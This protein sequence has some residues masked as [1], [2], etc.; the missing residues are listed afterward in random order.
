VLAACGPCDAGSFQVAAI[1]PAAQVTSDPTG[2]DVTY[3]QPATFSVACSGYPVP[4]VQW[5]V[6]PR[7]GTTWGADTVDT[8]S[9]HTGPGTVSSALTLTQ[10][11]VTDS[12][13]EY[14][15]VC[16]NT[17]GSSTSTAATLTVA[18]APL[19][20]TAP[21]PAIS[22]GQA[23]PALTPSY[24]G[25]VAGDSASSLTTGATCSLP[26]GTPAVPGAGSYT[27]T[28]SGPADPNYAIS[29]VNGTL[30][31]AAPPATTSS[32]T[33]TTNPPAT[34]SSTS[35]SVFV[36]IPPSPTT[37]PSGAAASLPLFPGA[38]LSYPNGAVVDFAGTAYVFAGGHAFEVASAQDLASVRKVDPAKVVGALPGATVP[39]AVPRP[40]TLLSTRAVNGNPTIYVMGTD[41]E[42]HAFSTMHQFLSDGYDPALVVTV[43]D[44]GGI[45]TGS[46]AGV[47]GQAVTAL[48]TR[49]DGAIVD[50]SGTFY[51][52]AG[53]EAFGIATP[54]EL[55]EVRRLDTAEVLE[56]H[57]ATAPSGPGIA[58]GVLL[59]V[60]GGHVF[61][62]YE[63]SIYPFKTSAQF[64]ADGYT[65]TAAVPVPGTGQLTV[66]LPYSGK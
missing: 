30:T 58:G 10:P 52:Y 50:S 43:P 32:T 59:G 28:C 40:G 51:V 33:P 53:Q 46:T 9:S 65:G 15:L 3:G 14:E 38:G 42:V 57:V 22:Y 20:V 16:T 23:V 64:G 26:A 13:N 41:G 37:T 6:M 21:S 5:Q 45:A 48:A 54:S 66:A 60:L 35:P 36:P 19:T 27:V 17:D 12:G 4:A 49:A 39:A 56:G 11:P 29:Y 24:T 61:V 55:A 44:L 18:P 7:G 25:L 31:V 8:A 63:G 47:A 1:D 34:T 62:S 2:Q